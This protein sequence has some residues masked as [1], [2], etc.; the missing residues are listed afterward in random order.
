MGSLWCGSIAASSFNNGF[1]SSSIIFFPKKRQRRRRNARKG[2]LDGWV[3]WVYCFRL[4]SIIL[5]LSFTV[6]SPWSWWLS[7]Y[8]FFSL[9]E[10]KIVFP[11]DFY[12]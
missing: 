11:R 8:H 5:F 3:D 7:Y 12:I 2:A 4:E 1:S 9:K 6:Q 10:N